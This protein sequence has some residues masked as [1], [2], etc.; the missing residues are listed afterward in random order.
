MV[1][2]LSKDG[3]ARPTPTRRYYQGDC[4]VAP[5]AAHYLAAAVLSGAHAA[6]D[7][8][9]GGGRP[10]R[11]GL[12]LATAA[13]LERLRAQPD[14]RAARLP[15][16]LQPQPALRLRQLRPVAA[17]ADGCCWPP[18]AVPDRRGGAAAVGRGH[19]ACWPCCCSS[20]TC[21]TSCS[22]LCAALALRA[23]RRGALAAPAAGAGRPGCRRSRLLV[24]GS[25]PATFEPARGRSASLVDVWN[26][27]GRERLGGSRRRSRAG[28]GR[29][30]ALKDPAVHTL[31][32]FTDSVDIVAAARRCWW[33]WPATSC[34]GIVGCWR[35]RSTGRGRACASPGG[36]PSPAPCSPTWACPTTCA[37][38]S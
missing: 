6:D 27:L 15:A 23:V 36:S 10:L 14:P 25:S 32:G 19:R 20:A 18:G 11:G 13:L 2:M 9:Q 5:Y 22:A 16:G 35:R 38:S 7:R 34:S 37:S 31:R 30:G 24:A 8:P 1:D 3:R 26:M 17:G 33:C 28:R 29:S 4:R 21:R 12:P